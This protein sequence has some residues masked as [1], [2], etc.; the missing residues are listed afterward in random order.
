MCLGGST[1]KE[2]EAAP[3]FNRSFQPYVQ[4]PFGVWSET[5][6]GG[7]TTNFLTGA[8]GF[9]Q[10]LLF[11]YVGLR[12]EADALRLKPVCMEGAELIKARG[13]NFRGTTFDVEYDCGDEAA[14]RR[15][16]RIRPTRRALGAAPLVLHVEGRE[17]VRPV[18]GQAVE[19]PLGE[20]RLRQ[21]GG[22]A[23][24]RPRG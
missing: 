3:L 22:A 24:E 1:G 6:G 20:V 2:A 12:I 18:M 21:V 11:G 7:G 8:G 17:G 19:L 5:A 14:G 23:G 16:M 4:Q 15:S 10:A 9:L 13:L